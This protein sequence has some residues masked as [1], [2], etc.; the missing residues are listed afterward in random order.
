MGQPETGIYRMSRFFPEQGK[1]LRVGER[2]GESLG[3]AAE[4]HENEAKFER[5]LLGKL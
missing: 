4:S 3:R 2:R 1:E 5:S